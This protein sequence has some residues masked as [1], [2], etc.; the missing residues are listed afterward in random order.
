MPPGIGYGKE[1]EDVGA[2]KRFFQ[3]LGTPTAQNNPNL[4]A[5]VQRGNEWQAQRVAEHRAKNQTARNAI[6]RGIGAGAPPMHPAHIAESIQE[7]QQKLE[8]QKARDRDAFLGPVREN[9]ADAAQ[10][11]A[12][13]YADYE[14]AYGRP[15]P[16]APPPPPPIDTLGESVSPAPIQTGTSPAPDVAVETPTPSATAET[17]IQD[18]T[19][20]SPPA[21]TVMPEQENQGGFF[22]FLKGLAGGL[23][24]VLLN[25]VATLQNVA[26]TG[27]PWDEANQFN[28]KQN[29]MYA[30]MPGYMPRRTDYDEDS[31]KQ[32][33]LR[34]GQNAWN[35]ATGQRDNE[36]AWQQYQQRQAVIDRENQ[37]ID[38]KYGHEKDLAAI[39]GQQA[40][41]LEDRNFNRELDLLGL[42]SSLGPD[43][44][45]STY[46]DS[47]S[48]L[49]L[50][51]GGLLKP[52]DQGRIRNINWGRLF[53]GDEFS[54]P[55]YDEL[56]EQMYES[57]ATDPG[58][59]QRFEST[60]EA[61]AK[62][63]EA[64]ARIRLAMQQEGMDIND[65]SFIRPFY[66][67]VEATILSENPLI[68]E[69]RGP[70]PEE[71]KI[72]LEEFR[73]KR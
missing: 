37:L 40:R 39:P 14:A 25:P 15:H 59:L 49:G 68:A 18:T 32:A 46:A 42:K 21:D 64:A 34:G 27:N 54:S 63:Q 29:E 8:E 73:R 20:L 35:D 69:R 47:K 28:L 4:A 53:G 48:L 13:M 11:Q 23:A 36:Q 51:E 6:G 30:D 19:P 43:A 12:K 61:Y 66:E 3:M 38:K 16:D 56:D 67:Q 41:D 33:N 22:G 24:N 65:P 9:E 10:D 62:I 26:Q 72:I 1:A 55:S 17:P 7:T 70:R 50:G 44:I 5:A 71:V 45:E 2:L 60:D 57:M 31:Y 52:Q 58:I